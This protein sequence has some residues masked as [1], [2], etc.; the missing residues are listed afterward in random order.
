MNLPYEL[1]GRATVALVGAILLELLVV[2]LLVALY[3][4]WYRGLT[5]ASNYLWSGFYPAE[6]ERPPPWKLKLSGLCIG[7][8]DLDRRKIRRA[9]EGPDR[10]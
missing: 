8:R 1:I 5:R 6:G 4:A 2:A 3:A 9:W 7:V 10:G